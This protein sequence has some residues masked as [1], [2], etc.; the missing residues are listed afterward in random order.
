MGTTSIEILNIK[1]SNYFYGVNSLSFLQL[2][3][4]LFFFSFLIKLPMF[5]FHSWLPEAHT[6][7][8]TIGSILLA[9]ILLKLGSFGIYRF[10]LSLFNP[11]FLD[12]FSSFNL[13][14]ISSP[15]LYPIPT[16][17]VGDGG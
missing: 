13:Y 4:V 14:N 10:S 17:P 8:P 16:I 15:P 5:P 9:A 3:W 11:F 6:E 1:F 12:Q 7:A 2:L